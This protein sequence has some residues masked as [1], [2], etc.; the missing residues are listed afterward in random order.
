MESD[1]PQLL[2]R[3][4]LELLVLQI[5]LLLVVCDLLCLDREETEVQRGPF[6]HPVTAQSPNHGL[7]H[8]NA[9][10]TCSAELYIL[11]HNMTTV[12]LSV[13]GKPHGQTAL[14]CLKRT[15]FSTSRRNLA[16]KLDP[17]SVLGGAVSTT[18]SGK[19]NNSL[20]NKRYFPH[21]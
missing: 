6:Q 15:C 3:A 1:F 12:C 13:S 20:C 18:D 4:A 14:V 10:Y 21:Q 9:F 2:W 11:S 19:A 5:S 7:C 17:N 16:G 8:Q